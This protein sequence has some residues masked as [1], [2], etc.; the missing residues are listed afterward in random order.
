M[1]VSIRKKSLEAIIR[2][3]DLSD[4]LYKVLP[5][6]PLSCLPYIIHQHIDSASITAFMERWQPNTNT[7]HMPW[8]EMTIML[9]DMQR[10]LG[11]SFEGSLTA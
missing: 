10:I 5:A 1:G 4:E 6:T 7:F 2:M 3:Q 9:H 11:I 8:G